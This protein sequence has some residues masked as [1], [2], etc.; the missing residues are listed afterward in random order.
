MGISLST[1]GWGSKTNKQAEGNSATGG[2]GL[3]IASPKSNVDSRP[4]GR[5]ENG[6]FLMGKIYAPPFDQMIPTRVH[7]KRNLGSINGRLA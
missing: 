1:S 2:R 3:P 4:L 6:P 5:G 7:N